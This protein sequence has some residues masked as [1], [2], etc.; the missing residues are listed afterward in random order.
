MCA[1][2]DFILKGWQHIAGGRAKRTPPVSS[3]KYS[4]PEGD[5]R[6]TGPSAKTTR[7]SAALNCVLGQSLIPIPFLFPNPI[8]NICAQA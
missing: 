6:Q 5:A 4:H 3:I 1:R 7:L 8:R 2:G